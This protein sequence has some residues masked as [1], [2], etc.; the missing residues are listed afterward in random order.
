MRVLFVFFVFAFNLTKFELKTSPP[1]PP[2]TSAPPPFSVFIYGSQGLQSLQSEFKINLIR[3][4]FGY[5]FSIRKTVDQQAL[6]RMSNPRH[7][8]RLYRVTAEYRTSRESPNVVIEFKC[9]VQGC[10]SRAFIV[11]NEDGRVIER[12]DESNHSHSLRTRFENPVTEFSNQNLR[13]W[14]F[15]GK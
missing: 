1:P 11:F 6:I 8:P 3:I 14:L 2:L 7:R 15:N 12:I 5:L 4:L 13:E 10:P 9:T